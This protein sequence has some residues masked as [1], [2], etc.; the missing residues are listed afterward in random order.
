MEVS[1]SLIHEMIRSFILG[2]PIMV[3]LIKS[4]MMRKVIKF[5]H[6]LQINLLDDIV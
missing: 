2:K 3:L 1:Q 5:I 6:V 4:F